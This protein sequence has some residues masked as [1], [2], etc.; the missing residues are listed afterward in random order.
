MK[1]KYAILY[2]LLLLTATAS[3]TTYYVKVGG[4]NSAN[5]LSWANA[6]EHPNKTN[7][8][9]AS[10][11]TV[12]FAPGEYDTCYI[13][14][15]N[16]AVPWTVYRCAANDPNDPDSGW[17]TTILRGSRLYTGWTQRGA[18]NTYAYNGTLPPRWCTEQTYSIVVTQDDSLISSYS[19]TGGYS[20]ATVSAAGRAF[21]ADTGTDSLIMWARGGDD[22]DNYEIRVSQQ[23]VFRINSASEGAIKI[24]GLTIQDA[25]RAAVWI[26]GSSFG[27]SMDAPDS[28]WIYKCRIK[29]VGDAI[30]NNNTGA[31]AFGMDSSDPPDLA[32]TYSQ[33]CYVRGSIITTAWSPSA[34]V[35]YSGG[36][37]VDAYGCSGVVIDSC[38]IQDMPGGGIV[39]KFGGATGAALSE[40][41]VIA[42]NRINRCY[43]GIWFGNKQRGIKIYGNIIENCTYRGIDVHSTG[44]NGPYDSTFICNNTFVNGAGTGGEAIT[45]SP[46]V[47]NSTNMIKWNIIFDTATVQRQI[48]FVDQ[49]EAPAQ[50]GIVD[51]FEIDFNMYYTGASSFACRFYGTAG[52]SGTN[53]TS[54]Q[55]CGFDANGTSDVNPNFAASHTGD[56][57]R[58]GASA[59][60][61][62]TY[63]GRTWTIVGAVQEDCPQ[64]SLPTI[65]DVVDSLNPCQ[66]VWSSS[67]NANS[68]FV[69]ID[70]VSNAFGAIDVDTTVTGLTLF[71]T[72][73]RDSRMTY[74]RVRAQGDCDTSA[75]STVESFTT[76]PPI[77]YVVSSSLEDSLRF[78][79]AVGSDPESK[80]MFIANLTGNALAVD[81]LV[82]TAAWLTISPTSGTTPFLTSNT[83]DPGALTAGYYSVQAYVY[84]S[85][86][87]NSPLQYK[88][89]MNLTPAPP[90]FTA[91]KFVWCYK[92][93]IECTGI[94]CSAPEGPPEP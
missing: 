63:G 73:N 83:A 49:S 80:V 62:T 5:G 32:T 28:I 14:P 50:T 35:N 21:Y 13:D 74:V 37:A 16:G 53:W 91:R 31:I 86:A 82:E 6:W 76:S 30:G 45:I 65:S 55:S 61:D 72:A 93:D 3:A 46:T 67:T 56:Y 19:A 41:N 33:F 64:V 10:G 54:W 59:E 66:I 43:S 70:T 58:P 78:N 9:I 18:S 40:N 75:W 85:T 39:F 36:A 60:I 89:A 25:T 42:F 22:P 92:P 29:N 11:D 88:V 48:G 69:E 26:A 15:P 77:L 71:Y 90:P 47:A 34:N 57:S 20:T 51:S 7:G 38:V 79:R 84:A 27:G 94:G 2:F 8:N 87:E 1:V 23:A 44:A 68:Y 17:A 81:S 12:I 52:C 4:N 24:I